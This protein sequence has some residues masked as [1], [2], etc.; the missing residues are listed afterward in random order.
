MNHSLSILKLLE[1]LFAKFA[2]YQVLQTCT[3]GLFLGIHFAHR[4]TIAY[5]LPVAIE[6][7][8][9]DVE[10]LLKAMGHIVFESYDLDGFQVPLLHILDGVVE[11][12]VTSEQTYGFNVGHLSKVDKLDGDSNIHLGLDLLLD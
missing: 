7:H 6:K 3:F 8:H 2:T 10:M 9:L 12:P 1:T 5:G 11:I 4:A